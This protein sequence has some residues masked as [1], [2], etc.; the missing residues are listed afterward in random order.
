[1]MPDKWRTMNFPPQ[2]MQNIA[3]DPA[4]NNELEI[5]GLLVNGSI[6]GKEGMMIAFSQQ[7]AFDVDVH[8][9]HT[10]CTIKTLLQISER[11]CDGAAPVLVRIV[12]QYGRKCIPMVNNTTLDI[13]ACLLSHMTH[14]VPRM[15]AFLGIGCWDIVN[16]FFRATDTAPLSKS[17]IPCDEWDGF[18]SLVLTKCLDDPR[19]NEY[20][21]FL[22]RLVQV[23]CLLHH[24]QWDNKT[25]VLDMLFS[26]VHCKK[27][28][29][30]LASYCLH[31]RDSMIFCDAPRPMNVAFANEIAT[32]AFYGIRQSWLPNHAWLP[33]EFQPPRRQ[34]ELSFTVKDVSVS[35]AQENTD[36]VEQLSRR[37]ARRVYRVVQVV[38]VARLVASYCV[39]TVK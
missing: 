32:W 16:A 10:E 35:P 12:V 25:N 7:D 34:Q 9:A 3:N 29:L 31:Y 30:T 36:A 1:M 11:E 14:K 38:P 21:P 17:N 2:L 19:A 24:W 27:R 15:A 18:I 39:G 5:L 37:I 4:S 20:S 13:V 22:I 6:P 8:L 33:V 23:M 26:R 28:L